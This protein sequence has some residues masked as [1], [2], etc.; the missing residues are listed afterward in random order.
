MTQYNKQ[1]TPWMLALPSFLLFTGMVILPLILVGI[2][3]FNVFDYN[4]GVMDSYT[5]SN[6]ITVITD[7]YYLEI[8]WRTIKLSLITTIICIFLGGS[9][10]YILA[11]MQAPWRSIFLLVIL[12]PL[13]VSVVV[14][15]FGWSMVLGSQGGW[16]ELQSLL[17]FVPST[18]LYTEYAIV[19]AL[20]HIMLP[21]MVIPVWT[22]LTKIDPML[23]AAALT[24]GASRF[25]AFRR[26]VLPQ[27]TLGI[28]SGSLLVFSL[29]A[30]SFAIPGLLGGRRLKMAA[31]VVYDE[32]MVDLNWPQGA[33][34]SILIL[35]SILFI[36]IGCNQ[37]V[38]TRAKKKLYQ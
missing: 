25:T 14:R 35:I 16:G 6:Y 12:G 15:A 34:I 22:S 36:M 28:L 7:S 29:S 4:K 24:L 18:L 32:F 38:E 27:A 5:W 10:A 3:S 9:E 33:A 11:R 8:F 17:G 37:Y 30:S 20:V 19:I 26:I 13:L 31:T 23:E 21:F 2:L 1:Y